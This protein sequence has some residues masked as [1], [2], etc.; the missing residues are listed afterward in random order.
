M[1]KSRNEN[2]A[3]SFV[4]FE[5]IQKCHSPDRQLP[6]RQ[7]RRGNPQ[8]QKLSPIPRA[9]MS[10]ADSPIHRYRFDLKSAILKHFHQLFIDKSLNRQ[11]IFWSHGD[12]PQHIGLARRQA[13]LFIECTLLDECLGARV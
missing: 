10:N 12:A 8:W 6:S 7:C 1:V 3:V 5:V 4:S 9:E 13:G 11:P 2:I